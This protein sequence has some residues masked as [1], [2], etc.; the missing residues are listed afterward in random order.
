MQQCVFVY[1]FCSYDNVGSFINFRLMSLCHYGIG[2]KNPMPVWLYSFLYLSDLAAVSGF[3]SIKTTSKNAWKYHMAGDEWI[4][5]YSM[6]NGLVN[7]VV[8][9]AGFSAVEKADTTLTTSLHLIHPQF[10]D[11][12]GKYCRN[13]AVNV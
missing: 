6:Q 10:H 1:I 8:Y 4:V 3:V 12:M 13:N 11:I 2:P 9:A 7:P 5:H